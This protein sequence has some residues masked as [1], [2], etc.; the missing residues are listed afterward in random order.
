MADDANG[1]WSYSDGYTRIEM[2]SGNTHYAELSDYERIVDHFRTGLFKVIDFCDVFGA[3]IAIRVD[4][5]ESVER[6][7]PD[8]IDDN[9]RANDIAA[10]QAKQRQK[11]SW[12]DE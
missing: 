2:V 11:P 12:M 10:E 1:Y 8:A 6:Q 3:D 4:R 7:T 5:I 9:V